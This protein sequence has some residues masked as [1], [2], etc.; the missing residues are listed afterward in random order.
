[1]NAAQCTALIQKFEAARAAREANAATHHAFLKRHAR[2]AVI[3]HKE[4]PYRLTTV[5]LYA[6]VKATVEILR[7]PTHPLYNT[8]AQAYL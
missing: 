8:I 2:L 5:R 1:M 4:S 3:I 6:M 7:N